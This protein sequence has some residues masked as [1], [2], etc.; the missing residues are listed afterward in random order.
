MNM[1]PLLLLAVPPYLV[2]VSACAW[3]N[4]VFFRMLDEVNRVRSVQEKIIYRFNWDVSKVMRAYREAYPDGNLGHQFR[5]GVS[6]MALGGLGA[7]S[8]LVLAR[9]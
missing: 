1:K 9:Q 4:I 7:A 6:L 3:A 8:V 5:L 2:G